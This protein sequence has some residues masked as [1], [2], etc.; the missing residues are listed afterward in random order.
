MALASESKRKWLLAS[1]PRSQFHAG[2]FREAGQGRE[3]L[4]P[5]AEDPEHGERGLLF[6]GIQ[7]SI[8]DQFEFLMTRWMGDPSRPKMPGGH[9]L[10]VGQNDAPGE[11][12][13]RRCVIFGSGV[14]QASVATN[15]Q[16]IIPTGGGYFFVPSITALRDVLGG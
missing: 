15:A 3:T 13:Q 4:R 16:W 5:P 7:A 6:L 11:D 10:L 14:Q 8:E 1:R 2:H 12:R 9:D